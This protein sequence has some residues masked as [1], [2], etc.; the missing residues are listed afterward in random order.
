M[1]EPCF[2]AYIA[3]CNK[4]SGMVGA[5]MDNPR[6]KEDTAKEVA[7]LIRTGF[8][9]SRVTNEEVRVHKWCICKEIKKG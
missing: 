3:R 1:T 5:V 7:G 6:H 2:E 8:A 9:V 4:C